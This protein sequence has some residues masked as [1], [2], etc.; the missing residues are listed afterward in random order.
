MSFA[1]TAYTTV[2]S[3]WKQ[4]AV[5]VALLCVVAGLPVAAT[6]CE[7]VCRAGEG[8]TAF[9]QTASAESASGHHHHH[10]AS[11][12]DQLVSS[13][14][15]PQLASP[16]AHD[17]GAP[18]DVIPESETATKAWRDESRANTLLLSLATAMSVAH[19]DSLPWLHVLDG[20]RL[21]EAPSSPA[22]PPLVLRV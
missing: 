10:E 2:V 8:V 1:G 9:A 13:V 5:A 3:G 7:A 22:S 18:D 21:P 4:R 14:S 19:L 20:Q 11:H 12:P 6:A 16:G 17:C 15:G